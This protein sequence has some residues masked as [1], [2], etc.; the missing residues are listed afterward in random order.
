MVK[1]VLKSEEDIDLETEL[2]IWLRMP[3]IT[4]CECA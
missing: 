3:G 1:G 4:H 2:L